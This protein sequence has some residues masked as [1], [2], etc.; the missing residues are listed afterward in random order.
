VID[1]TETYWPLTLA[2]D[3]KTAGYKQRL[4]LHLNFG[5]GK[6]A[7]T[8][9]ILDAEGRKLPVA[10]GYTDGGKNRYLLLGETEY[11]KWADVVAAY[12]AERAKQKHLG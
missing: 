3:P 6:G 5:P 2:T 11:K 7:A 8:Y 9:A 4:T 12:P 1:D 10:Y